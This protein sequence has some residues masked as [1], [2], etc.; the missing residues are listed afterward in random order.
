MIY[1]YH[2]YTFS[3]IQGLEKNESNIVHNYY[4]RHLKIVLNTL[5]RMHFKIIRDIIDTKFIIIYKNG[6]A[7]E[8]FSI[9]IIKKI[10]I[11]KFINTGV[12]TNV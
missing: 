2:R 8:K 10:I 1:N 5:L 3:S 9:S 4:P 6:H 12:Y 7:I 11:Q